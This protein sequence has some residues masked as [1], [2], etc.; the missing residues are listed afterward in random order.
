MLIPPVT[1]MPEDEARDFIEAQPFGTWVAQVDGQPEAHHLPFELVR[2]G[3]APD[4]LRFHVS[5]GNPAWQCAGLDEPTLVIFLG[6]HAYVSPGWM[7]ARDTHGK[8][9]PGWNYAAV[10]VWGPVRVVRDADWLQAHVSALSARME[11]G[12]PRPWHTG[13]PPPG[14]ISASVDY[15]VGFEMTITRCQGKQLASQQYNPATRQAIAAGLRRE[16]QATPAATVADMIER[17]RSMRA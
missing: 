4:R 17:T 1:A 2:G 7:P 11:Q 5:R 13:E 3:S 10:H 14:F 15:I 8:V 9:A 6:A 16:P 12:R